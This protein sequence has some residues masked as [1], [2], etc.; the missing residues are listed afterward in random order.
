MG[1]WT[2]EV[3]FC[4]VDILMNGLTYPIVVGPALRGHRPSLPRL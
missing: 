2:V 3:R 1:S 4:D